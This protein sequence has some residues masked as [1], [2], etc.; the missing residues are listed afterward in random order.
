VNPGAANPVARLAAVASIV[1]LALAWPPASVGAVAVASRADAAAAE[2]FA[3]QAE[4]L[5]V[6]LRIPGLAVVVLRDTTV[7][8]ARGF[9]FADLERRVPVTPDTP[10]N[11]ASVSKPISAVVALRLVEQGRLD[12]DRPMVAY[13]GF[14]E[15]CREAREGGGIFFRD[16]SCDSTLT[17]RHVMS[18]SANGT[19][20]TRFWYNPPSYSWASRPMMQVTKATFSDLVRQLVLDPAGMRNSARI[21]RA[22]PLRADLA[23]TLARPYALDSTGTPAPA[24]PPPPQGDGAAGGVVSTAMDLARFDV[25]L[26]TGRLLSPASLTA[27][28]APG[29]APD[30]TALPYGIGW[31][32]ADVPDSGNATGERLVWHTGLWEGAYSALYL[33]APKRRLALILLANSDGLRWDS[34]FDEAVPLRSPF[35]RSLLAEFGR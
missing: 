32:V 28:W 26:N 1:A 24:P 15:F 29:R 9:G 11:I 27:M 23:A 25:A 34:R 31:F 14:E 21:N 22:L 4:S 7:V 17:L 5:R 2:R 3:A 12:L 8:L 13:T 20:G 30:G 16:Y 33:R 19:P 6:A 35:V 18:M 10:F